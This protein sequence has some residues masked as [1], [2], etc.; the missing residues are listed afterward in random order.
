MLVP[1][2]TNAVLAGHFPE[3]TQGN[4]GVSFRIAGVAAE[5]RTKYLQNSNLERYAIRP[6]SAPVLFVVLRSLTT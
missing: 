2:G 6:S 3:V 1:C 5:V 4:R